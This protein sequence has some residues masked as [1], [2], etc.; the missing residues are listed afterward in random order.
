MSKF[1]VYITDQDFGNIDIEKEILEP[2]DAQVIGLNCKDGKNI[3]E[4]ARDADALIVQYANISKD[5]INSL[6]KLKIIARY[7]VGFDTID[8]NAAKEKGIICTNVE[9]YCTNEVANHNISLIL[10][11]TK[12][13]PMFIEET[14][15]GHWHWSETNA[16]VHRFT[17]LQIGVI[18]FGKI[19]Q[20]MT[21]KAQSLGFNV[22][23]Y[24]PFVSKDDME[25]LKVY[26]ITFDNL[27]K[28]SDIVVVQCPYN[29]KTHHIIGEKELLKMKTGSILINCSRGKLIDN[30]ALYKV[31]KDGHLSSAAL[32]DIEE[33]PAKIFNWNPSKN[34]LFSLK[35]CF[36]TPHVAYY[37]EE[38]LMEARNKA[39]N[40]VKAVLLD[41]EPLYRVV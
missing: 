20:N 30:E 10:M 23:A 39:A 34:P 24:D 12:R 35:N 5:T 28:T 25:K 31:L 27:L 8:I 3:I 15:K 6:N 40:N 21:K 29:D 22:V 2:I 13:I 26:P 4:S 7:G 9:D 36:I 32:D 37:S 38:A 16:A 18:G 1:K 11:L 41:K 14:K 33:E 19:A 17:N